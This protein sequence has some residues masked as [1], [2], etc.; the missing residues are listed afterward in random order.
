ME[1][2]SQA[3]VKAEPVEHQVIIRPG[4]PAATNFTMNG[5][6]DLPPIGGPE[7]ST[8]NATADSP[9]NSVIVLNDQPMAYFHSGI[10]S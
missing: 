1:F 5:S 4:V 7:M 9:R 8:S 2:F 6:I 3:D 10:L